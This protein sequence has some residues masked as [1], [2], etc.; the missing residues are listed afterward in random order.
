[1]SKQ[2]DHVVVNRAVGRSIRL[3]EYVGLFVVLVATLVAAGGDLIHMFTAGRVGISDLLLL[4]M[5]LE[6]IAMVE[7]YWRMG[8]LPVRMPLYIAMVGIARHLMVDWSSQNPWLMVAGAGAIVLL[9]VGV[10]IVRYG[11][12]RF[13]YTDSGEAERHD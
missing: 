7:A 6:L 9:A 5:Y 4:F 10:L 12:Q 1:M 8:K 3:I 13:P 11:H 2:L